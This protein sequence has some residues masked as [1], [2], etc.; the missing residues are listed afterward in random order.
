MAVTVVTIKMAGGVNYTHTTD[1]SA[2]WPSVPNDTYFY[3]LDTEIVYYKDAAGT[4]I[5]GY[6]EGGLTTIATDGTTIIGDGTSS[7]PLIALGS[8]TSGNLF[9]LLTDYLVNP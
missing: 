4:V 9:V 3:D 8:G 1:T 6:E 2:D 5:N 7:S